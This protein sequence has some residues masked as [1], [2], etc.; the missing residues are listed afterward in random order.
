MAWCERACHAASAAARAAPP[1]QQQLQQQAV[2]AR[3]GRCFGSFAS[4]PALHG[5]A[6]PDGTGQT[7]HVTFVERDGERVEV[8]VHTG[9]RQ[10]G[11]IDEAM[12]QLPRRMLLTRR[13]RA[14]PR[15][16]KPFAASHEGCSSTAVDL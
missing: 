14:D 12:L 15:G 8:E 16:R 4:R 9:M 10:V 7:I 5:G 11:R 3:M 13:R 1:P 6:G 2:A